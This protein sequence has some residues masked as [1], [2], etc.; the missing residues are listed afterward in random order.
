MD[1]G[2]YAASHDKAID[3]DEVRRAL[4]VFVAPWQTF[5]L[6]G[7]PSA[8]SI[9]CRGDDLDAAVEAARQLSGGSGVY[10]TLNPCRPDLAGAARDKGI[11]IRRWM[12]VDLDAIRPAG[13]NATDVEKA[14]AINAACDCA[15]YLGDR[16]WPDPIMADSGNGAHLLY[17]I[18]LANTALVQQLVKDVLYRLGVLFDVDAAAV[19]RAVHNAAR[20]CKL[21]GTWARKGPH[22]PDRPH[23][24]ARLVNLPSELA[25]V[26]TGQLE[27]LRDEGKGPA[28]PRLNGHADAAVKALVA[29]GTLANYVR[30]A[31]ERECARV[32]WAT[33]GAAEGRNNTLNDAAFRLAT[34]ADWPELS[35]LTFHPI[36]ELRVAASL[37][38]LGE[39]EVRKTIESGWTAGKAHPRDRQAVLARAEQVKA[40]G[41][42]EPRKMHTKGLHE[43]KSETVD[44]L[45]EDRI[46]IGF[47]SIFAGRTGHGKS[48]VMCDVT[49]RLSRGE[50]APYS[51]LRREPIRT[52]IISEDPVE[53]ML[54]PRLNE[55]R[56]DKMM[57]RFMTWESMA[58]FT[59]NNIAMLDEVW[60]ECKQ[61]TLIVIDPPTNFLGG[62]DEHKNSEV[63]NVLMSLVAWLDGKHIAAVLITH[64]NKAVGKG[65]DAIERIIG[66]VAWGSVARITVG[67]AEDP[68]LPGQMLCGG[69]K[70][71]LGAKAECLAFKIVKTDTL[72][73]IEWVGKSETSMDDAMGKVK[74]KT[75]GANAVEWLTGM[76]RERREWPSDDL[77][78]MAQEIGVTKYAL[79]ESPE[80]LALPIHKRL[81]MNSKGEKYWVWIAD[82]NWP[83]ESPEPLE[84]STITPTAESENGD[85]EY[86]KSVGR[87]IGIWEPSG[88]CQDPE[89]PVLSDGS[90]PGENPDLPPKARALRLLMGLM[91][92]GPIRRGQAESLATEAG[93][94]LDALSEAAGDIGVTVSLEDGQE[95]W[96]CP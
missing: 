3:P 90:I 87:A 17:R 88:P 31:I 47:I 57:V 83:T 76:F 73:T 40:A 64:I 10:W 68:D 77:R 71:N 35:D 58:K 25:V 6:R 2:V 94:P 11:L 9:V 78:R 4:S 70:N 59:L 62:M 24:L 52:L 60:E 53:V 75:R 85:P 51:H 55:L 37:A 50:P 92:G 96:S 19:D 28:P 29:A 5:E 26:T 67:F 34:M 49:A 45:W 22:G 43:V 38:G 72:A 54:A 44:W 56:A 95:T 32:R 65:F 1:I 13:T 20:I 61:P 93:I 84:C 91:L 27:A 7:L 33:P 89:H 86:I 16:G 66:S 81:R 80:V 21:P 82:D 63:R 69:S 41:P 46:A 79:F 18:D 12:L 74:K 30:S 42:V 14:A 48:F 8:R 23:R 39:D 15:A 36:T